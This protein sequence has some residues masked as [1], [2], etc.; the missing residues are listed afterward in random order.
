MKNYTSL[1]L[2]CPHS[3]FIIGDIPLI[4]NL[5]FGGLPFKNKP[6]LTFEV[7]EVGSH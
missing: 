2:L 3:L 7:S 1:P 5:Y 4:P 6:A